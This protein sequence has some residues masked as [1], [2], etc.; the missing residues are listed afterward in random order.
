MSVISVDVETGGLNPW[1]DA[2]LSLG[3]VVLDENYEPTGKAWYM[4]RKPGPDEKVHDEALRINGLNPE[5]GEDHE[6][7]CASLREFLMGLEG[8]I[9]PLGHNYASFDAGFLKYRLAEVWTAYVH[10]RCSDTMILALALVHAGII[11]GGH[12]RGLKSLC[13]RY[14]IPYGGHHALGDAVCTGK[15][16]AALLDEIR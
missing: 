14:G 3:I 12:H 13:Q 7:F 11:P 15:L 1:E 16:Y 8:P 9:F 10:Y 2:L 6:T 4:Q 5:E